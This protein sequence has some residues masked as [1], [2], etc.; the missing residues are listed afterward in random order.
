LTIGGLAA[1]FLFK[2]VPAGIGL[3]AAIALGRNKM[4]IVAGRRTVPETDPA[5][6]PACD[7]ECHVSDRQGERR[8]QF[9]ARV[10]IYILFLGRLLPFWKI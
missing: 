6:G 5:W 9:H 3:T 8:F 7:A 2:F 10:R 4:L 1:A